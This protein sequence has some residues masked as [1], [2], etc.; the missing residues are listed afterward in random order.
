MTGVF[1]SQ[2]EWVAAGDGCGT[3]PTQGKTAAVM[4]VG[5]LASFKKCGE[6][7]RVLGRVMRMVVPIVF[8]AQG[9]S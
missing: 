4:Q 6:Q 2:I 3:L 8:C 9:F 5:W 1:K 7:L